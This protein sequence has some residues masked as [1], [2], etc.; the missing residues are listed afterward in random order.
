MKVVKVYGALKDRL[1]EGVFNFDVDT[2][3]EAL[4]AL[5]SNFPGLDKWLIDSEKDG[6]GYRV[7]LGENQ[8]EEENL[9]DLVLPWSDREV[10]KIIPVIAGAGRGG[11]RGIFMGA[12]LIGASFLFPGAGMF[13]A[14]AGVI[15]AGATG[16][17]LTA[18][19]AVGTIMSGIGA[20]MILGGVSELIS[21]TP[22]VQG[23]REVQRNRN[24]SFS[25]ITNPAQTGVAV[26]IAYGRVF[27]GSAVISSGLDVDQVL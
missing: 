14:G 5:I 8:I 21:P 4:R 23:M 12:A 26:P 22:P 19:T 16:F 9:T 13:G 7:L 2:P 10:F 17:T 15:G 3:S 20:S 6:I 18:L 11:W 25:G 27:V 24:Y 1:G